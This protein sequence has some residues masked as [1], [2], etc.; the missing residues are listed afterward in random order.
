[1]SPVDCKETQCPPISLMLLSISEQS[2][3]TCQIKK[4]KLHHV[5]N[6]FVMSIGLMSPV[7]F[8]KRL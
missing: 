4:K 3:N 7:D 5:G 8:K 2:N 1:M 6:N